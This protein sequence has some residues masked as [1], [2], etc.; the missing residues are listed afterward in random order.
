VSGWAESF[1]PSSTTDVRL[2][3]TWPA[4]SP[5]LNPIENIWGIMKGRLMLRKLETKDE[6]VVA[7]KQEWANITLDQ[8]RA[9]IG[10]WNHRLQA[11]IDAKGG[12]TRY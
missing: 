2:L 9:T 12:N 1:D 10:N 6:L 7:I 3:K 5:D 11:V 4:R 8:I